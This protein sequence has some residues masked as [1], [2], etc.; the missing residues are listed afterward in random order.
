MVKNHSELK[1]IIEINV[2]PLVDVCLVLVIIFMVTVPL[3]LQPMAQVM[4]PQAVTAL[5]ERKDVVFLTLTPEDKIIVDRM[6]LPIEDLLVKLQTRLAESATKTVIIRAD[7]RVRYKVLKQI[8][9]KAK[10]AGAKKMV[11]ATELKQP[12]R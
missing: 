8:V 3:L 6:E 7:Q 1:T 9:D 10:E 11:F 4:L 12:V 5:E 2:T